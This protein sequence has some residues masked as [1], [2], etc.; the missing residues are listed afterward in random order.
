ML[1]NV[2]AKVP[3][4][5]GLR[6][7]APSASR[8]GRRSS[9]TSTTTRSGTS[10][11][12]PGAGMGLMLGPPNTDAIEPRAPASYGEVSGITQTVRNYGASLGLA[13][14][15]TDP[16]HPEPYEHRGVAR[17]LRHPDEQGRRDRAEP[18]AV[19]RRQ[20]GRRVRRAT[21]ARRPRRSSRRCSSTSPSALEGRLLH[22]GGG[23]GR[24]RR[25]RAR[26]PPARPPGSARRVGRADQPP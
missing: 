19:E 20:A 11:C 4:V 24:R 23:T 12:S 5:L 15:G 26:R 18:H 22:H 17:G 10:S 2:G 25:G 14:L 16:H 6:A 8:S 7:S 21:P 13:V 9:P 1:D 3:V